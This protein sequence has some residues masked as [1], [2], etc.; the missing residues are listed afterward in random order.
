MVTNE[1]HKIKSVLHD[2]P[3]IEDVKYDSNSI[4][5]K[6]K[7]YT[8]PGFIALGTLMSKTLGGSIS[9]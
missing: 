7:S 6:K 4:E 2:G 9:R 8:K 5:H 1:K 3:N